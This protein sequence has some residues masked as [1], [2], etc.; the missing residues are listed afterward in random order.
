M[1]QFTDSINYVKLR[2]IK[3]FSSKLFRG[4]NYTVLVSLC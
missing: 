2:A 4:E 1:W 3:N